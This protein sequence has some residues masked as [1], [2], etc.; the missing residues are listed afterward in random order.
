LEI[1][2]IFSDYLFNLIFKKFGLGS[3]KKKKKR[4]MGEESNWQQSG[5]NSGLQVRGGAR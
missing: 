2:V 5:A 3:P 1:W 4:K